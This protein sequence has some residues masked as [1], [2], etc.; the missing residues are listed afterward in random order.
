MG[1]ITR[2]E[3][4]EFIT[5]LKA[6]NKNNTNGKILIGG[7]YRREL[8]F[9]SDIDI[10]WVSKKKEWTIDKP[11]NTIKLPG[12]V[13]ETTNG[14]IHRMTLVEFKNKK[15]L[16]DVFIVDKFVLPFALLYSTGDRDTTLGFRVAAKNKNWLLNQ[17]GLWMRDNPNI[18]VPG[19]ENIKTE[20]EIFKFFG[21]E[22]KEPKTRI[23]K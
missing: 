11:M 22:Y 23:P 10:L 16:C 1:K 15:I 18:R 5:K 8:P 3:A 9:N 19:T 7:S 12:V 6:L 4:T 13:L 14:D 20:Q 17:Y 2:Q 21:M